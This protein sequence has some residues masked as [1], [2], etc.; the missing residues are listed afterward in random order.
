VYIG[1]RVVQCGRVEG[2]T[3]R[4]D[5]AN[6]RFSRLYESAQ[7]YTQAEDR[8]LEDYNSWYFWTANISNIFRLVYTNTHR[9]TEEILVDLN[10]DGKSNTPE[11]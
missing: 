11:A 1:S 2:Q 10:N 5:E 9:D 8:I 3:D 7:K 4:H 6:S